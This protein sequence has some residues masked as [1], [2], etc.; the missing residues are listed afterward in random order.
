M[1]LY[2]KSYIATYSDAAL[3]YLEA[4]GSP[5]YQEKIIQEIGHIK[6]REIDQQ[7]INTA[8]SKLYG[9]CTPE[10]RNRQFYT[11]FI[12]VWS[13]NSTGQNPL[14][15]LVRWN[16]PKIPKRKRVV[17]DVSYEDAVTFINACV[18]SVAEIMTF[19]FWTGCRPIE[20][21]LLRIEDVNIEGRWITLNDTKTVPR[22]IPVHEGL[23]PL[24]EGKKGHVFK[25]SHGRPWPHNREY[26]SSGRLINSRGG[27]MA[28]PIR[29]A[30]DNTGINITAYTARHTV[31]TKLIYP[32]GVSETIKEEI[33]GHDQGGVS[34][35]YIH[36]PCQAHI[37]A[38]NKLPDPREL[39]IKVLVKNP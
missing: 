16:R 11:P 37:D 9:H 36:L 26:S 3:L 27:Q 39:G 7:T 32:Y 8:A 34:K 5:R 13:H 31:S 28:T 18:P 10:T 38:I 35:R 30:K 20:A 6:V 25:N 24:F 1:R 15:P 2:G 29:T 23:L 17:K 19:L 22:G 4:G 12:A 33:L 21:F 14:C